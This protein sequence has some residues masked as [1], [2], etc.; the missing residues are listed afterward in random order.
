M[1]DTIVLA[2]IVALPPT[3]VS[4]AA[5]VA[6]FRGQQQTREEYKQLHIKI[7]SRMDELLDLTKASSRA[8]GILEGK[9]GKRPIEEEE[10]IQNEP[11]AP[12]S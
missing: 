2:I 3:I 6:S 10:P 1:S 5:L 8:E 12:S 4:L 9:E 7:N 11:S